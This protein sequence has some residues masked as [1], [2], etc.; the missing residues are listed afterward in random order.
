M[1]I[2]ALVFVAGL[3][4][5]FLG[6]D[7][8]VRGAARLAN[9]LGISALLVGLTVV[10]FGNSSPEL[11]VGVLAAATGQ[12]GLAVGNVIGSNIVNIAL[13]L[14]LTAIILPI[15]VRAR[16]IVREVPMMIAASLALPV[17]GLNGGIGRGDAA[18]LLLGFGAYLWFVIKASPGEP[19]ERAAEFHEF[20]QSIGLSEP[21][22]RPKRD[23]LLIIAGLGGLFL[24][25]HLLVTSSVAIARTMGIP[26]VVIGTTIVAAGT[27]LPELTT[28][29]VA[30]MRREMDIAL[31]NLVGSNIFNILAILGVSAMI[32]PLPLPPALLTFELPAMILFALVLLPFAWSGSRL[33]RV[34]G[35]LLVAG[36]VVFMALLIART[37]AGLS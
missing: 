20:E 25:A 31:G 15:R 8:L 1:W 37:T 16:L 3:G 27:S 6:A 2:Q 10:A 30:A 5:L 33:G 26:E 34:E 4:A 35:A 11:V 24:G 28:S 29:V 22:L 7:W 9:S 17:L 19:P 23:V 14:G 32:R 13:I 21:E 12:G 36:Y 18:L